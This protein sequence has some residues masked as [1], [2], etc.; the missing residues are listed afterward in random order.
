MSTNRLIALLPWLAVSLCAQD[1][2][3][4][5]LGRITDATG[6]VVPD[7]Q[8]TVTNEGTNVPLVTRS[9]QEGN[10]LAPLLE[11]GQYTM[12]LE[13]S[14]FRKLVR[15]GV[16]V[17]TGDKLALDF[18]LEVGATADSITVTGDVPLLQTSSADIAQVIDRR[19]MDLLYISNR[20]PLNLISLTPGVQGGGGRFADSGQHTFSVNGGGATSGNNEVVVDGASVVMP[21]QGGSIATSPSGDTVEELRVQTTM[22]DAAYGHS[23]GGVVSYAT[24]SGTNQLHG[25]FEDFYRNSAFNA[26]SWTNNKRGVKKPDDTRQFWSGAV[27]GPVYLPKLYDGRNRTFFFTS[28]Q[29]EKTKGGTTFSGRVPTEAE[30]QGDFSQTLN[31]QGG[32]LT[33]Y[34]PY[35]TTVSGTTVTRQPFPGNRIPAS[36]HN[37]TGLAIANAFPKPNV[38]VPAQIGLYNWVEQGAS[39]VP[40]TQISQRV[41]QSVSGKQRLFGRFGFMNYK[42]EFPSIPRGLYSA[43]IGGNPNGDWR[44]FYT[45]SLNDDYLFSPTLILSVRYNFGRYWSDT[46]FSGNFQ[47][48]KE[49]KLPDAIL[50]NQMRPAWPNITMGEGTIAFGHRFKTRANDTHA[51]V[52]TLTKLAG[53]HTFRVGG[54][55]RLVNWNENSP[56]THAAGYFNFSAGFTQSDPQQSAASKTSG[57]AM[58]SLIMGIPSSGDIS[59]PTPYALRSF[60]YGAYVQDDWKV[61]RTLTLNLGVRWEVETPYNERYDHIY[62]GFDYT[63]QNPVQ[64]PGMTLRGGPLFA[65]INGYPRRQGNTDWNNLGP[66]FGFAWQVRPGTVLRGGY[67]MFFSSNIGNLDTTVNIPPTFSTAITYIASQDRGFTPYTNFSNPFPAGIPKPIGNSKG[68]A[69]RLGESVSFLAQGRVLPY[70]QQ[71]QFGI[72]HSLPSQIRLEANFV[73]QLSLKGLEGFSLNEK[74]DAYLALGTQENVQV[75][76]PFYGIFPA[77][78]SM[79]SSR[80]IAQRQLWLRYPQFSGVTQNASNTHTVV[81]HAVQL[82]LEKRLT[83]GLTL[84]WNYTGSKMI[85]NN[86]TSLVNTRHYRTISENDTPHVI[87]MAFVYDLPFGPGRPLLQG[88]GLAGKIIGGWSLSGRAHYESGNPLSISDSNGR[89]IRIR[90]ASYSGA[91]VNR[92]GD[93]VDPVTRQVLNPYFDTTAFVSLPSQYTISP[94]PPVFGELRSPTSKSLNASLIKRV[95]VNERVNVDV[96]LDA[97]GVTNTPQWGNPGTDM[98]DKATFGVIN[99]AGGARNMQLAFRVVF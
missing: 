10:Y 84:L 94:E 71:M 38:N 2:R 66:R 58:A 49:L 75:P 97:S 15:S 20:N 32:A 67:G 14:G 17:R 65:G 63:A 29:H 42:T 9:N 57:T 13:S 54:E 56:D 95:Q 27:G 30:R 62:Y 47:D 82:S 45:A 61:S 89:P 64:V 79:G 85:E 18:Q 37:T 40:S 60:Y 91:I 55:A 35:T 22:F 5:I 4:T 24:R 77:E 41:D 36:L 25:S 90:D 81:Y 72:Q 69:S 93:K 87:N 51:L 83:H 1:Y 34:N 53:S 78:V 12:T 23:N 44:H 96:R 3:G 31:S 70:T 16:T 21:R 52:P 7:V 33:I 19:F 88:R 48:P 8:I 46:W 43:P 6:A 86:I 26:N 76:N 98:K 92:I 74:P 73:R 11:P 39:A 99:T 59:G 68:M 50:A 80:T 28:V